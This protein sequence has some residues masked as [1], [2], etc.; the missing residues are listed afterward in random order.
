MTKVRNLSGKK[1]KHQP[2]LSGINEIQRFARSLNK[3]LFN[4]IFSKLLDSMFNDF[5]RCSV[6]FADDVDTFWQLELVHTASLQVVCGEVA[7]AP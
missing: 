4:F 5:L 3:G 7:S 2:T 1:A 6:G